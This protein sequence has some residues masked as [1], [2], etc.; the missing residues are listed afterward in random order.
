MN[1][2]PGRIQ[3]FFFSPKGLTPKEVNTH[4]KLF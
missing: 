2:Q 3:E 4:E 1:R